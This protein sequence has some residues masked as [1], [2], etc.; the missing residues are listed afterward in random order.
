MDHTFQNLLR[1][2][3]IR[4]DCSVGFGGKTQ[5]LFNILYTMPPVLQV[6]NPA[7]GPVVIP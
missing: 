5:L 3:G 4:V 7:G 2:V 6:L 1:Y